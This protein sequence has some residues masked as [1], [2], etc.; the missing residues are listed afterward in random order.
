MIIYKKYKVFIKQLLVYFFIIFQ[1]VFLY[2]LA[3]NGIL[4]NGNNKKNYSIQPSKSI[5]SYNISESKNIIID[6]MSQPPFVN[7]EEKKV[8][9][10]FG[11]NNVDYEIPDVNVTWFSSI[12]NFFVILVE[13]ILWLIPLFIV[14]FLYRYRKY[15]LN[16]F[17]EK[18]LVIEEKKLPDTLF[19]LELRE[20]KLPDDIKSSAQKLWLHKQYREAISLLYRSALMSLLKQYQFSLSVGATEQ[21]CVNQFKKILKIQMLNDNNSNFQNTTNQ[22]LQQ[23]NELTNT[24]IKIAYAHYY[25]DEN[26]FNRLCIDWNKVFS[27]NQEKNL[28]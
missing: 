12:L 6:I 15:W 16:V 2:V 28:K 5:E 24:W 10:I 18:K 7:I 20:D 27:N 22:Q 13:I 9:D 3:D 8:W 19:G 4:D 23:F 21:D 11:D 17:K 14:Y 26:T 1:S 25:P